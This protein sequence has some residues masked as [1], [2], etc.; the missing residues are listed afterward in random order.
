MKENIRIFVVEDALFLQEILCRIFNE[1][2]IE[3][4][5]VS[6]SGG[7]QTFSKIKNL[8]PDVVLMDLVL[9]E[10]NGM[11]LMYNINKILPK[12]KVIVCSSLKKK[13]FENQSKWIGDLNFIE[14]PFSSNAILDLVFSVVHKQI[15]KVA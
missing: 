3:V 2:N 8:A 7:E 13:L 6:G 1:A 14:K 4:V 10:K 15:K 11:E 9:P 5:G 12:T